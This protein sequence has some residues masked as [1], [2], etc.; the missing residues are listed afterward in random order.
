MAGY[1]GEVNKFNSFMLKFSSVRVCTW[2][3]TLEKSTSLIVFAFRV[4][5]CVHA[6]VA[7]SGEKWT[8]PRELNSK[9]RKVKNVSMRK[10]SSSAEYY[11]ISYRVFE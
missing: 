7:P 4:V 2:Q 5:E 11:S 3:D 9:S 6:N 10:G 1:I 8:C